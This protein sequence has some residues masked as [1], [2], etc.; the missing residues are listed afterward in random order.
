MTIVLS[1]TNLFSLELFDDAGESVRNDEDHYEEASEEDEDGRQDVPHVLARYPAVPRQLGDGLQLWGR[2]WSTC[3]KE[4]GFW[5]VV[6]KD[7]HSEL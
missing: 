5:V 1:L 7:L 6:K 2:F 4:K 3:S